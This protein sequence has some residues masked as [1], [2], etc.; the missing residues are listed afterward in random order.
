MTVNG[1]TVRAI[2]TINGWR[3]IVTRGSD[4]IKA[5]HKNWY[6]EWQAMRSGWDWVANNVEGA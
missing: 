5:G 4:E 3:Y 6:T 1:I 2:E